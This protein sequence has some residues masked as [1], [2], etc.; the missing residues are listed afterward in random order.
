M[1]YQAK[2]KYGML[3]EGRYK[4][5][6]ELY[7]LNCI[8]HGDVEA[9]CAEILQS[10]IKSPNVDAIAK[11]NLSDVYKMTEGPLSEVEGDFYQVKVA[12]DFGESKTVDK[13]LVNADSPAQA[14]DRVR[15]RLKNVLFD[16]DITHC[17]KTQI[18]GVYDKGNIV[19][20]EDF[21]KRMEDLEAKGRKEA[22]Y[23]QVDIDFDTPANKPQSDPN[24][25]T[26]MVLRSE[27]VSVD[28]EDL[29]NGYQDEGE[30]LEN[31]RELPTGHMA[32]LGSGQEEPAEA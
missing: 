8:S 16:F 28:A 14:E 18:L 22:N 20:V 21:K 29:N 5:V 13:H 17:D 27:V 3:V 23:N 12:C 32:L 6:T 31:V 25:V 26:A 19:W 1:W 10:R 7:L 4:T 24:A 15:E 9:T 2:V 30:D 11:Q